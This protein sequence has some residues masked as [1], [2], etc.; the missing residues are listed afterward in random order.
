[1]VDRTCYDCPEI[2]R[3]NARIDKMQIE[4]LKEFDEIKSRI[5]HI[6]TNYNQLLLNIVKVE[7]KLDTI[8]EK[9][10][11][12]EGK[13]TFWKEKGVSLI[14]GIIQAILIAFL[15]WRFGLK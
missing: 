5:V 14:L 1:V 10:N 11:I 15:V 8:F 13:S 7:N 6:D 12:L 9:L 3:V 4:T 2:T